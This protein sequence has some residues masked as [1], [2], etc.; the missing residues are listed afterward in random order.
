MHQIQN[1]QPDRHNKRKELYKFKVR[2]K[3]KSESGMINQVYHISP[4]ESNCD[5]NDINTPE[6]YI[7][8]SPLFNKSDSF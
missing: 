7:N 4:L 3:E 5:C 1:N 6:D 8:K 2:E